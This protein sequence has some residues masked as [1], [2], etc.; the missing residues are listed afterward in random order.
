MSLYLKERLRSI[1]LSMKMYSIHPPL[2]WACCLS[3]SLCTRPRNRTFV[4]VGYLF[5]SE[6]SPDFDK[7]S[8]L[9]SLA[10]MRK[11]THSLFLCI[12]YT[13][14]SWQIHPHCTQYNSEYHAYP[15]PK[16]HSQ[17]ISCISFFCFP[18][19][20]RNNSCT[21]PSSCTKHSCFM[22]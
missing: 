19:A 12:T 7:H 22:I 13:R 18:C 9:L 3:L 5:P 1:F 15:C 20:Y 8:C 6:L 11:F 10:P 14:D 17:S 21:Q 2:R 16:N 4:G